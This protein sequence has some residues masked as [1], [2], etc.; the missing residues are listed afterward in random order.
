V[1]ESDIQK[2]T[3]SFKLVLALRALI[4]FV[5]IRATQNC[6]QN[7]QNFKKIFTPRVLEI[8]DLMKNRDIS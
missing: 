3:I 5:R 6:R 4:T 7:W 1:R 8:F 2:I